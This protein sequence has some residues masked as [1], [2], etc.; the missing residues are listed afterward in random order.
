M[1]ER[2]IIGTR[3]SLLAMT[4][5]GIVADA[6]RAAHPTLT[7]ELRKISTKGDR[8]QDIPLPEIGAKGLFTE[9]LEHALLDG[10][11]DLAV[12]SAKDLPTEMPDRLGLG[13]VPQREDPRDAFL[14]AAVSR[15]ED[16]P[17]GALIGTSSLR[18]QAQLA[19]IR[20]DFQ[21]TALRGNIDT[22]IKKLKRG[23]CDATLLATAG[24]NRAGLADQITHHLDIDQI[25]P[26]PGQGCLALQSRVDDDRVNGWLAPLHHDPS[27]V[28]LD[29][30]RTITAKLEGGCRA[31]IG[32]IVQVDGSTLKCRAVVT[33]P[34]G[35]RCASASAQATSKDQLIQ[36]TV[37]TLI[38]GGAREIIQHCRSLE[39]EPGS[40]E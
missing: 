4:Q 15:L 27:A 1:P 14:A 32:V 35:S 40:R 6:L 31:P 24:L 17:P 12:H 7:V 36:E 37:D 9:E 25:V 39:A 22:R 2:L 3:G 33:M 19:Q 8:R 28:A 29:A 13:C 18:R 20:P 30:E 5:S 11:I 23:D 16:L 21:F 38:A 26:A 34:D 10:R